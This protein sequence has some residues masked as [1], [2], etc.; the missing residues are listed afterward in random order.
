M[1]TP[2]FPFL[3]HSQLSGSHFISVCSFLPAS[4]FTSPLRVYRPKHVIV[5]KV[6][7]KPRGRCDVSSGG[8]IRMVTTSWFYGNLY[9]CTSVASPARCVYR[10]TRKVTKFLKGRCKN[11]NGKFLNNIYHHLGHAEQTVAGKYKRGEEREKDDRTL[12]WPA[13]MTLHY[14]ECSVCLTDF[15]LS[16]WIR[17]LYYNSDY[18]YPQPMVTKG[19]ISM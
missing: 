5:S 11:G 14:K 13:T 4:W 6:N 12:V 1:S 18:M 3:F 17:W 16:K 15:Q 10:K 7:L 2:L 8:G 9:N 19:C